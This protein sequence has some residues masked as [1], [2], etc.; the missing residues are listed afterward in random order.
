MMQEI[1]IIGN[2]TKDPTYNTTQTGSGV[3]RISVAVNNKRN[4]TTTYY[5]VSV[6][7][8]IGESVQKHLVKGDKVFVSGELTAD[9]FKKNDGD[10]IPS[11]NVNCKNI[12]FLSMN[13]NNFAS[14]QGQ[15][16]TGTKQAFAEPVEDDLPF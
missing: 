6:W 7:G 3:S 13:K 4:D 5:N 14:Q 15:T 11:L 1:Q 8:K 16:N 10:V 12:V 9:V 2:L